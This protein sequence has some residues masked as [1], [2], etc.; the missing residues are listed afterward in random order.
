MAA[1]RGTWPGGSPTGVGIVQTLVCAAQLFS[2]ARLVSVATAFRFGEHDCGRGDTLRKGQKQVMCTD[3][4]GKQEPVVTPPRRR[5]Q[6]SGQLQ[7]EIL[8]G[9]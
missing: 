4:K 1:M 7:K 9:V 6:D 2:I 8:S 5:L 3:G